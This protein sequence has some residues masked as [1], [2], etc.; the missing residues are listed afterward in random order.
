MDGLVGHRWIHIDSNV[1]MGYA[2]VANPIFDDPGFLFNRLRTFR[3]YLNR[4][5][6][7]FGKPRSPR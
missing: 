1:F 4:V 3:R 7:G 5:G 6:D 2:A